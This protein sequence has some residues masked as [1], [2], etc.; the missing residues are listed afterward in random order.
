MIIRKLCCGLSDT[1]C[2]QLLSSAAFAFTL[3][4]RRAFVRTQRQ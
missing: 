4:L 3:T 2:L 1:D